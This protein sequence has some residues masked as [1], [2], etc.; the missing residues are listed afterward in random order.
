MLMQVKRDQLAARLAG[1]VVPEGMTAGRAAALTRLQAMGLP[2]KRDEY[3][4]YTDPV[5]LVSPVPNQAAS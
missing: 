3:W 2:G 5:S 4:R 1:M